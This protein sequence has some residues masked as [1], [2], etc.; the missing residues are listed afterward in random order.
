MLGSQALVFA[1]FAII[2]ALSGPRRH[3][4]DLVFATFVAPKLG[5]VQEQEPAALPK[6]AQLVGFFLLH[7][8]F[9][10]RHRKDP[11]YGTLRRPSLG[12]LG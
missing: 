3:P 6:F 1:I 11:H 7:T 12:R 8:T 9:V 4:C 5:Q 10:R 2:E